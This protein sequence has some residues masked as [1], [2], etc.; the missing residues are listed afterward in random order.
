MFVRKQPFVTPHLETK[1]TSL[2]LK[3]N[4]MSE[5]AVCFH[6]SYLI[7]YGETENFITND[8]RRLNWGRRQLF[9]TRLRLYLGRREVL[10]LTYGRIE[11][12]VKPSDTIVSYKVKFNSKHAEKMSDENK[13]LPMFQSLILKSTKKKNV[14][15]LRYCLNN[16][17]CRP[18]RNVTTAA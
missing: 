5:S 9:P 17:Y 16:T 4:E 18:L 3:T 6:S 7:G 11:F 2:K 14:A 13:T 12:P 1:L 15:C 10:R 8:I